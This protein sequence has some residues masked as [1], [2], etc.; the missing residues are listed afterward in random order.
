MTEPPF[1]SSPANGEDGVAVTRETI[2]QFTDALNPESVNATNIKATFGDQVL[3]ARFHLSSDQTKVT[4]F[5]AENLP[6]NATIRQHAAA[7]DPV[8]DRGVAGK[9]P[10]A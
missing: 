4:L 8:G 9:H 6:E 7:P 1:R 2:L 10:K 5:Y 3:E